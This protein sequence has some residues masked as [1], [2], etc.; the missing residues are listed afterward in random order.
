M[1]KNAT[2]QSALSTNPSCVDK[3]VWEALQDQG[4]PLLVLISAA[5]VINWM[6]AAAAATLGQDQSTVIGL[7]AAQLMAPGIAPKL[8]SASA[9]SPKDSEPRSPSL[10]CFRGKSGVRTW[11]WCSV[12][13]VGITGSSMWQLFP[14]S[15]EE[16]EALCGPSLREIFSSG[17][18]LSLVLDAVGDILFS[19]GPIP[20]ALKQPARLP[21]VGAYLGT[22]GL[23]AISSATELVLRRGH[24]RSLR[25]ETSGWDS[26]QGEVWNCLIAPLHREQLERV[27]LIALEDTWAH[28]FSRSQHK[29]CAPTKTTRDDETRKLPVAQD[30]TAVR[31]DLLQLAIPT[32]LRRDLPSMRI[33]SEE[34]SKCL[35]VLRTIRR[36]GTGF[37]VKLRWIKASASEGWSESQ[38][39]P[40][41]R[42]LG[43]M[44]RIDLQLDAHPPDSS[45]TALAKIENTDRTW[46]GRLARAASG[47]LSLNPSAGIV[48]L[49]LPCAVST[50]PSRHTVLLVCEHPMGRRHTR[51]LLGQAGFYV[52]ATGDPEAALGLAQDCI[53][54][55]S[56]LVCDGSLTGLSGI[57]LHGELRRRHPHVKALFLCGRPS[58]APRFSGTDWATLSDPITAAEL[59]AQLRR[60]NL[61]S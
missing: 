50:K 22:T 41:L 32:H 38:C 60:F 54:P 8:R 49:F 21:S 48:S 43:P 1:S 46:L 23:L 11:L 19:A 33:N 59:E 6:S 53:D 39:P 36:D 35:S 17:V 20:W 2:S 45:A 40:D 24:P 58:Q 30:A 42:N 57:Q 26:G 29:L 12:L 44:L 5:G 14:I 37:C 7:P 34:W 18:S 31:Q 56:L 16:R 27:S 15:T 10:R 4:G 3:Q 55:L 52:L 28:A 25:V 47:R 51:H 61:S 13:S 9:S